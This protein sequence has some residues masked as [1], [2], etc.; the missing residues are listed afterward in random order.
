MEKNNKNDL[1]PIIFTVT[2]LIKK[3]MA[4]HRKISLFSLTQF[5]VLDFVAEKETPTM[6]D[7]ADSLYVTSPS[8]T[9]IIDHLVKIRELERIYDKKDRRIIHLKLTEKGKKLLATRRKEAI[10][11]MNAVLKN[12]NKKEKTDLANILN[13]IINNK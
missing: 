4:S 13:K 6:K 2:R 10:T 3:H 12:L 9:T 11:R 1:I 8:A 5:K 7:V